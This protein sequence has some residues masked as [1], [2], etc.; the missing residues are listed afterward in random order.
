MRGGG[1]SG[2]HS[3]EHMHEAQQV[4]KKLWKRVC[5]LGCG[6]GSGE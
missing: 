3:D 6:C 1:V 4:Q 2:F 5:D